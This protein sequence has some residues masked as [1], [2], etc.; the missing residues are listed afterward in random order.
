M[1]INAN[2]ININYELSGPESAPVV[3][4]SHSLAAS[5]AMWEPQIAALTARYRVLRY[6]LRGHGSSD[7]PVG[8]YTFDNLA[9]DALGLLRA[10]NIK[11]CHFVGLSIG[12]MIGQALG[13]RAAPEIASLTL[14]ATSSRMPVEMQSVWDARIAQ[15]RAQGVGSIANGT[16]ERWF[17]ALFHTAHAA[18]VAEVGAMIAGTSAEGFAGCASAIKTL[19]LTDQ[20]K[21]ISSPTLLIVGRDDPGTPVAASEAIQREIKGAELVVLEN[22]MHIC[23]IEQAEAFNKAL[24]GFLNQQR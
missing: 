22:A 11:R 21:K 16:M 10:L 7:V 14:C 19:N 18:T 15:V 1:K 4:L 9:D 6:D 12:G 2:G 20:L 5:L 24:L 23:N 13:L 8:P 3:M 17:T